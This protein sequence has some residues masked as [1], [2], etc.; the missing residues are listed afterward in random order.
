MTAYGKA[1]AENNPRASA[2]LF[3]Q[4]AEYYETPFDPPMVG[5]DAIREYWEVGAQTL[6]DKECS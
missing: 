6:K 4:N 5:R 3:S 2:E 1:S